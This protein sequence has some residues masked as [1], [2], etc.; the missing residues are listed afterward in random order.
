MSAVFVDLC[1]LANGEWV[2]W[3]YPHP[4]GTRKSVQVRLSLPLEVCADGSWVLSGW[5]KE[6]FE[7]AIAPEIRNDN[8]HLGNIASLL[9]VLCENGTLRDDVVPMPGTS[10]R[11]S[12]EN[13]RLFSLLRLEVR[14]ALLRKRIANAPAASVAGILHQQGE[15]ELAVRFLEHCPRELLSAAF[16]PL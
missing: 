6:R 13:Q 10:C 15:S 3:R 2:A 11:I 14:L 16:V 4:L 7:A 8:N 1:C 12:C 9:E 5:P